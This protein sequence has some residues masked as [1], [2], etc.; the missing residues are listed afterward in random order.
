[1]R[2][3]Q[4]KLMILVISSVSVAAA[5]R[6]E[7][8]NANMSAPSHPAAAA[9]ADL[10]K[11]P[12]AVNTTAGAVKGPIVS[13]TL[14][15]IHPPN[16]RH[17]S[18]RRLPLHIQPEAQSRFFFPVLAIKGHASKAHPRPPSGLYPAA[19]PPSASYGAPSKPIGYPSSS[20]PHVNEIFITYPPAT[21]S[22][23]ARP[24][25]YGA[26]GSSSYLPPTKPTPPPTHPP[27]PYPGPAPGP[28]PNSTPPPYPYPGP[29][30]G[31]APNSTP[32]PYPYPGPAPGPAPNSTP[33]PYP[34][35]GPGT[36]PGPGQGPARL[37]IFVFIPKPGYH[38]VDHQHKPNYPGNYGP[39]RPISGAR[40][41]PP[42]PPPPPRPAYVYPPANYVVTR[43]T[44][45]NGGYY[46][47]GIYPPARPRPPTTG[48]GVPQAA[49]I[50]H[51]SFISKSKDSIPD[52]VQDSAPS[53]YTEPDNQLVLIR[54]ET[55]NPSEQVLNVAG[56]SQVTV[57]SGSTPT[58]TPAGTTDTR[59]DG[60][61]SDLV[62]LPYTF[63]RGV[64]PELAHPQSD[65]GPPGQDPNWD[66]IVAS[67][68]A[69]QHQ[70]NQSYRTDSSSKISISVL[71]STIFR[72]DIPIPPRQPPG[73]PPV[74]AGQRYND[75]G[76]PWVILDQPS[77]H[78]ADVVVEPIVPIQVFR[79]GG[80]NYLTQLSGRKQPQS[81]N[82]VVA[83]D[84]PDELLL[85]NPDD[86]FYESFPP[87]PNDNALDS[88]HSGTVHSPPV[89]NR[90]V[91]ESPRF[92]DV[93]IFATTPQSETENNGSFPI[94]TAGPAF[95]DASAR[96]PDS[97]RAIDLAQNSIPP[98]GS[99]EE[100]AP[101]PFLSI[102]PAYHS[103]DNATTYTHT[104][105]NTVDSGDDPLRIVQQLEA[106]NLRAI[107]SFIRQTEIASLLQHKGA[108]LC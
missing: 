58:P 77:R 74:D 104:S 27:Y 22:S 100:G 5:S 20:N 39:S 4:V 94:R 11:K 95:A 18:Q 48:Y 51:S 79:P 43:P 45:P 53:S 12:A 9:P 78:P 2:H 29:G 75:C 102:H 59:T 60:Q 96:H 97:L 91:P 57:Y 64:A 32:T 84:N 14:E 82:G 72:E 52:S 93:L 17:F 13:T 30:P 63:Q 54:H 101:S 69:T 37:P 47:T 38:N 103:G 15:G 73:F 62:P 42:P 107:A 81:A 61:I 86:P 7:W 26:G 106:A 34:Y 40:P 90:T 70:S 36:G 65:P 25:S 108:V 66:E 33:A 46:Q 19:R 23:S 1:M 49:P 35:P 50:N 105:N 10:E 41:P 87:F 56:S 83:R 76:G 67:K 99:E 16:S 8:T 71:P 21:Q 3:R 44:K 98:S 88:A 89:T 68:D 31:P 80:N 28:A 92:P 85:A 55:S 24:P 6:P